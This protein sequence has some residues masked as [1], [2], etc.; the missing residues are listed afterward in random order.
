MLN[1]AIPFP[2]SLLL[3]TA[4]GMQLLLAGCATTT[5]TSSANPS[6]DN[7]DEWSNYATLPVT[8]R[9][10]APGTAATR[11]AS[12]IR[13][14]TP[15]P[16]TGDRRILVYV[17]PQ[18][19]PAPAALCSNPDMFRPGEQAGASAAVTVALCDGN[20]VVSTVSGRLLTNNVSDTWL[21]RE[22]GAMRDQLYFS[23][24][25]GVNNPN[26]S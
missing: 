22:I 6:R 19:L 24:F 17:N 7:P 4:I 12:L 3:R 11:L 10:N 8:V 25:P 9:G 13:P 26:Y 23:L 16:V 1:K 14:T 18:S 15:V 5:V 20:Q 21:R 2:F